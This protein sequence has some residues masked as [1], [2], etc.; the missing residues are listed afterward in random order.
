MSGDLRLILQSTGQL[1][2]RI[3]PH[4]PGVVVAGTGITVN[5]AGLTFTISADVALIAA[6]AAALVQPTIIE[7]QMVANSQVSQAMSFAAAAS[8]SA[9]KASA[10]AAALTDDQIALKAA[11][12][13]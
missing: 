2:A 12:F 8:R 6:S 10:S 11:V 1:Q 5:Q 4:F 9:R 7:S 13:N 3:L